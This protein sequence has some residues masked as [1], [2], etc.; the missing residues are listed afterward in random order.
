MAIRN[1]ESYK[2]LLNWWYQSRKEPINKY[3]INVPFSFIQQIFTENLLAVGLVQCPGNKPKSLF[4]FSL[5]KADNNLK[6]II[7]ERTCALRKIKGKVVVIECL[8]CSSRSGKAY[9]SRYHL[10]RDFT[11]QERTHRLKPRWKADSKRS[12]D[13]RKVREVDLGPRLAEN[14]RLWA[15]L[16][17]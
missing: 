17:F 9:L 6:I 2:I 16:I 5:R 14:W 8:D 1:V 4:S 10:S 7:W 11:G 12:S 15:E 3:N 13:R